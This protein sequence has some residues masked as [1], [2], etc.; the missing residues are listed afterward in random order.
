MP[1]RNFVQVDAGLYRGAQPD[2]EGFRALRELGVR[3]VVNLR[4][5]KS[6]SELA[7]PAGLDLVEIPV[8]ALIDSD[9][10]TDEELDRFFDVVLDASRRPAFIHCAHGR[11][12]TGALC[13]VYRI[14][15]QGWTNE[16]ALEEMKELGFRTFYGDLEDFVRT[17]RPRGRAPRK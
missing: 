10:P 6:D 7:V 4:T 12:R 11:D 3:T 13:A 17:Y 1:I 2:A 9:P 16:R 15:A 8:H 5:S 14:E